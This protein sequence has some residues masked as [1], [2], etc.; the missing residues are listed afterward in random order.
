MKLVTNVFLNGGEERAACI[1]CLD[2]V[3]LKLGEMGGTDGQH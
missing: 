1:T 3:W 2:K